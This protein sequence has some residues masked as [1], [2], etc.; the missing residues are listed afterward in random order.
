MERKVRLCTAENAAR[1]WNVKV[2]CICIKHEG[3]TDMRNIFIATRGAGD[4]RSRL[5]NPEEH[6][7][8]GKSAMETAVI[9]ENAVEEAS[10]LPVPIAEIISK[11]SLGAPK[12]LMAVAE[13]K[14]PLEGEGGA[15]QCDVW[16]LLGTDVGSVSLSVEAKARESFGKNNESL[17]TWLQ[18]GTSKRSPE[19]RR[20]RWED[21]QRYLPQ[22][23]YDNVPYQILHRC[24]AG[25]IEADRFGLKNAVFLV[26][27]FGA[28]D[29]SF[30]MYSLFMNALNLPA[31]K[32]KL[33]FSEVG[34]EDRTIRLGVGWV[35][36]PF[37]SDSQMA[38]C[39]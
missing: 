15:S 35:D 22:G 29:S 3:T 23:D 14:V 27:S 32:N 26:Q 6:W 20:G 5:G 21:I 36:C 4:W 7:V 13:H 16:A 31:E 18:G 17:S 1:Y 2:V 9:W 11:S 33:Y 39:L 30:E 12:L 10:G 28:P 25:V 24:A 37:A 19:N 34:I 38:R 8:R